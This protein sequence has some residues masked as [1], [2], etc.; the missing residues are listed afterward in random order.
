MI[1]FAKMFS[2]TDKMM[3][4][5]ALQ[6][7]RCGRGSASPN[8]M[9]GAVIT[10]ASGKI[11]GE[12]FHRCW[13]GPHAEVNAVNS[14]ADKETLHSSTIY[15]T[16]EPCSHFGK[17]PPCALLLR[18]SGFRRVVV[19]CTDPFKEVSGRGINMLREAG[20][21]VETGLMQ[22]EAE[23]LNRRFIFAHTRRRPYVLLK[24][25]QTAGGMM[26][27]P[28]GSPL[29]ISTPLSAVMMHRER[30]A[31]DAILAG[32]NTLRTDNP[33]L[34]CR[35]WPSRR[36]RPVIMDF[37]GKLPA[38]LEVRSNPQAI[39]LSERMPLEEMLEHLYAVHGVTSLMVEGGPSLLTSFINKGLWQEMRVETSAITGEKGGPAA[40]AVPLSAFQESFE[41]DGNIIYRRFSDEIT[42]RFGISYL[43]KGVKNT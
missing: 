40:P 34:T 14:V 11:T 37:G 3:M 13:G 43:L 28:D 26:A 23:A 36:L 7:A 2:D 24:W 42:V 4:T 32:N 17:T 33:S 25:A 41:C 38:E 8:P 18:E 15:V 30:A 10:D 39:T 1:N 22:K 19:A 35:L 20:I 12:G 29:A 27:A 9:V 21:T 6:L 31:V 16:L 5:R